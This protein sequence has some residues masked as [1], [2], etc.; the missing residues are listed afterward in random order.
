VCAGPV[1]GVAWKRDATTATARSSVMMLPRIAT[2][3]LAVTPTG[4]LTRIIYFFVG[5]VLKEPMQPSSPSAESFAR[6][7]PLRQDVIGNAV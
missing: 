3:A 6:F 7:L 2:I 5:A 4:L 1:S